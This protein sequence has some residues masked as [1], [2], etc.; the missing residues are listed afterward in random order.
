MG[1]VNLD[2]GD[3]DAQHTGSGS[4][5]RDRRIPTCPIVPLP[6]RVLHW[7]RAILLLYP[8]PNSLV[9]EY[10]QPLQAP[11]SGSAVGYLPHLFCLILWVIPPPILPIVCLGFS[12]QRGYQRAGVGSE[13]R[14]ARLGRSSITL[15]RRTPVSVREENGED[16]LK[17]HPLF[18]VK[19]LDLEKW[20]Q[21]MP[22]GSPRRLLQCRG[23]VW[24]RT[25]AHK[26]FAHKSH[27][28]VS[29]PGR[30]RRLSLYPPAIRSAP[31]GVGN[32]GPQPVYGFLYIPVPRWYINGYTHNPEQVWTE[33]LIPPKG[34]EHASL[35]ELRNPES[36]SSCERLCAV[37]ARLERY[38]P[39]VVIRLPLRRPCIVTGR[40]ASSALVIQLLVKGRPAATWAMLKFE[41][42]RRPSP[43]RELVHRALHEGFP[44]SIDAID[45]DFVS[46]ILFVQPE[47]SFVISSTVFVIPSY[48]AIAPLARVRRRAIREIQTPWLS[49]SVCG[50]PSHRTPRRILD[51]RAGPSG[52]S[53]VPLTVNPRVT[54][55]VPGNLVFEGRCSHNQADAQLDAIVS[56][57]R[58]INLKEVEAHEDTQPRAEMKRPLRP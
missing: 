5:A 46:A 19:P 7:H 50:V 4:G 26:A 54:V 3:L 44:N 25:F 37:V 13:Y 38:T 10:N 14:G 36:P 9:I 57:I 15:D 35:T 56:V 32:G 21:G 6:S 29:S 47:H 52:S 28:S 27:I 45:L 17:I 49:E 24:M 1:Y 11:C 42:T 55:D 12:E 33:L 34:P 53:L 23:L 16:Q 2:L 8:L 58:R 43:I 51:E 30:S 31:S 20:I 22:S 48:R 40:H 18:D 39:S 41:D